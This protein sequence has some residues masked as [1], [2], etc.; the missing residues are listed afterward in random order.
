MKSLYQV[1]HTIYD[2]IPPE[3]RKLLHKIIGTSLL[4][5]AVGNP[6]THLLATDQLNI[7][8]KDGELSQEERSLFSSVNAT[9]AEFAAA[10]SSF[11]QGEF[12]NCEHFCCVQD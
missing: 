6:A 2:L 8:C 9:A 7:Y 11:E 5:S 4:K 10:I 1:T 3:S 12:F